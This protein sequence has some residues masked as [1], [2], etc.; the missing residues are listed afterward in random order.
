[1]YFVSLYWVCEKDITM[2][3]FDMLLSLVSQT[4]ESPIKK[5]ALQVY[6]NLYLLSNILGDFWRLGFFPVRAFPG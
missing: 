5:L 3:G 6:C 4:S 1:M 2:L